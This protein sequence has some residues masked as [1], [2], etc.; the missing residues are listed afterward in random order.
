MTL[1]DT[2]TFSGLAQ[3]YNQN[4]INLTGATVVCE[5]R[6]DTTFSTTVFSK[7]IGTGVTVISASAGTF[8]VTLAPSD[9]SQLGNYDQS[10]VYQVRVTDSSGN[11]TTV[12]AGKLY[13]SAVN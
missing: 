5:A 10:L 3:D 8:S 9:T 2:F 1:G 13:L 11:V 12:Q 4:I 7:A 6:Y